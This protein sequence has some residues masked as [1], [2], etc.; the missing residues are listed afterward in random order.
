MVSKERR[1]KPLQGEV[2]NGT[3][4][5]EGV[6]QDQMW[7]PDTSSKHKFP[8]R[9]RIGLFF[10]ILEVGDGHSWEVEG[11]RQTLPYYQ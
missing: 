7:S 11:Q 2:V 3:T 9:E 6:C 5:M 10:K 1:E 4:V 8:I